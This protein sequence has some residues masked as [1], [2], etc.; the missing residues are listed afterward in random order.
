[1]SLQTRLGD[2][3]TAIGTDYKQ[4]RTWITGSSTG[5]LTGLTTT[6]KTSLVGAINEVKAGNSGAPP[7]ATESVAGIA[8]VATEAE[9]TTGTDDSRF[10]TPLKLATRL[11]GIAAQPDASETAKGIIEIATQAETN[12]GTDDVRAITPLKFQTRMAAYAQPLDTDLTAIAALSTTAYGRAFLALADQ[13]ALMTLIQSS[14]ETVQGIVELATSAE[15]V[16]GTDTV[17]ATHAAG[18]KAAIDARIDNN[19]ALGSSTVNAPSQAAVK[20]YADGLLD[21]NNGLQFKGVI[22]ASANPNYPAASAGHQYKIS[23][24]GKIGGASGPNVEVG[25]T[26]YAITDGSAAGTHAAVGANWVIVQ[27]NIDG[28]VTG[29]SSS[30]SGNLPTFSGTTGKVLQDSG[31]T[32][33][34]AAIGAGSATVVPTSAQVVAYAQPLDSD[35]TAIAA[36]TTTAYGRA[37][38]AL[39]DQTAFMALVASASETVQGKIEIATQAEVTTGTDDARAMTPLKYRTDQTSTMGNPETDLV[40][41][42]TAA[43]A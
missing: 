41:L 3:I 43:K 20:A 12:T 5:T 32:W 17:R 16:T 18:T 36:L 21:A 25:D 27:T 7:A 22:D 8:E 1:M 30:T 31:V 37:F 19:A 24:A 15:T 34:N 33:S 42:Y 4:I 28:A 39:A 35:L 40:A 23:V 14:S 38:L 11:T 9:V 26:L 2:L 13:A 6:D 29:P 10:V